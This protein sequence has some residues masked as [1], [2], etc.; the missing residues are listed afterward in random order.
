[1]LVHAIA[2]NCPPS[3][4]S[5]ILISINFL[6]VIGW[7]FL[8][9]LLIYP[10]VTK[11]VIFGHDAHWHLLMA[12]ENQYHFNAGHGWSF[13][14]SRV[15]GGFG[16]F[17]LYPPLFSYI[18]I[19]SS[20]FTDGEVTRLTLGYSVAI[21][22]FMTG[23][24]S[25]LLFNALS[26]FKP[27]IICSILYV[28]APYLYGIGVFERGALAEVTA[29]AI[30]PIVLLGFY[31]SPKKVYLSFICLVIGMSLLLI[32]HPPGFM[33][34]CLC[35]LPLTLSSL[36]GKKSIL[37]LLLAG[38]F[39]IFLTAF[40]WVP[41]VSFHPYN[42]IDSYV[43]A[44]D[45][46]FFIDLFKY[47]SNH[48]VLVMMLLTGLG[49]IFLL[50]SISF[51]WLSNHEIPRFFW[52]LSLGCLICLFFSSSLSEYF[53]INIQALHVI[54]YPFRFIGFLTL[55]GLSLFCYGLNAFLKS[56]KFKPFFVL[57]ALMAIYFYPWHLYVYPMVR[58]HSSKSPLEDVNTFKILQPEHLIKGGPEWGNIPYYMNNLFSS[59]R[60]LSRIPLNQI[61]VDSYHRFWSLSI[62]SP[63]DQTIT[64][65]LVY[66]PVWEAYEVTT[67]GAE[68]LISF[69]SPQGLMSFSVKEGNHRYAVVFPKQVWEG[70]ANFVSLL[71][72]FLFSL[73]I[74][75]KPFVIIFG[76]KIKKFV[77]ID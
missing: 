74:F 43:R 77:P 17:N 64:L 71:F 50:L 8:F 54:R 57:V 4:K 16:S 12:Q 59:S 25:F 61:K 39:T 51:V 5:L 20:L 21:V 44:F 3:S 48:F 60:Y 68:R 49:F 6:L 53:W 33:V 42:S 11:G 75:Y 24:S 76:N 7:V 41:F 56:P 27:A 65:P 62:G 19:F 40:Y 28:A 29:L 14:L 9:S 47:D 15:N 30:Y 73:V 55:S 23:V 70:P 45:A 34:I 63:I 58:D 22:L 69:P 10:L 66:V 18:T 46:V 36:L 2:R 72:L 1:M 37:A 31:Y 67:E 35:I 26:S 38:A 32:T 52:A 13:W